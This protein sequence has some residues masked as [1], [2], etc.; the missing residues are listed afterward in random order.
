MRKY[1]LAAAIAL[2]LLGQAE[3]QDLPLDKSDTGTCSCVR[4]VCNNACSRLPNPEVVAALRKQF[5]DLQNEEEIIVF[6]NGQ[7]RYDVAFYTARSHRQCRLTLKPVKLT[8]CRVV[9]G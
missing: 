1:F 2:A 8:N 5:P 3:A 6:D 9:H 4:N 7:Q